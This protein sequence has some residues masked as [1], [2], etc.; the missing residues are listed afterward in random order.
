M[1]KWT[2]LFFSLMSALCYMWRHTGH[3]FRITNINNS[4]F[5]SSVFPVCSGGSRH[6]EKKQKKQNTL[7][8]FPLQ[9]Y[10]RLR[11][12]WPS[13]SS[14]GSVWGQSLVP[15]ATGCARLPGSA[16][17]RTV[18]HKGIRENEDKVHWVPINESIRRNVGA[19]HSAPDMQRRMN[20]TKSSNMHRLYLTLNFLL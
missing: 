14:C 15:T 9:W 13:P 19:Q 1:S 5:M 8:C 3:Y 6:F 7:T 20:S 4:D 16:A 12:F 17:V 11:E 2:V 10:R 18:S